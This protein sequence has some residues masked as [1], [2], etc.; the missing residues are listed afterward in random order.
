MKRLNI[1]CGPDIK[2]K[3]EG[4]TNLDELKLK[5]VDVTLSKTTNLMKS[6]ART[7]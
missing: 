1:G 5:G 6:I 4:W 3:E 7:Y 2:P